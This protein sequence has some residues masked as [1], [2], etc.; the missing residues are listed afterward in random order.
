MIH[1]PVMP[2]EV[3]EILAPKSGEFFV[4]GTLGG[5]GHA[6]LILEAIG[7]EGKLLV[8]DEDPKA[9]KEFEERN[10]D[11][12]A[13]IFAVQ[14]NFTNIPAILESRGLGKA[15]GLF[16][17][18]GLSSDEIEYSGRG[19]TFQKNEPLFMTLSDRYTPVRTLLKTLRED[20]LA[21]IIRDYSDEKYAGAIAKEIKKTLKQK[22]IDTTFDLRESILRAIPGNYERGRIDPATRSFQ[23]LRIYANHE[24]ENIESVFKNLEK[25]LKSGARLAII[26]FHSG[27]DRLVKNLMRATAQ[28]GLLKLINKKIIETTEEEARANPRSRSAKL[29]AAIYTGTNPNPNIKLTNSH[30]LEINSCLPAGRRVISDYSRDNNRTQ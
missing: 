11:S 13:K 28:I 1:K 20:E 30:Y 18:L 29:R 6:E 26:S 16:L 15:D 14:D 7:D 24:F 9:V 25:I 12:R 3:L 8:V 17:D 21:K 27:E 2:R 5:G 4:D 23:A 22:N 19:F 10:K